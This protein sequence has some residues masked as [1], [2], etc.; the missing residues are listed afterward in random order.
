M[1][2]LDKGLSI[3]PDAGAERAP[4]SRRFTLRCA[5]GRWR[6]PRW[7]PCARLGLGC[8]EEVG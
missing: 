6:R 3:R 4:T 2:E 5:P 1:D 8:F 7:R